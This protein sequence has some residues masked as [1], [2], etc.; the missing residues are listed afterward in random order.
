MLFLNTILAWAGFVCVCIPVLIGP[1]F[2]G[3]WE[4]WWFWPFTVFIF[5][6]SLFLA[7]RLC[8]PTNIEDNDS[9]QSALNMKEGANFRFK[10]LSVLSFL[11]FLVYAFIRFMQAEVFMDAERSLLLF[12]TPFLLGIQI[13]FGFNRKMR[14]VLF[15]FILADLFLLGLYGVINH[16]VW[17]STH[18]LWAEGYEQYVNDGRATGS[19]FCPDH[20]SGIM[21]LGFCLCLGL[22]LDRGTEWKRKLFAALLGVIALIGVVLSK[23]RGGGLTVIVIAFAALI[24][25]FSQWRTSVRW[26]WRMLLGACFIMILVIF[27]SIETPYMKRFKSYFRWRETEN[28]SFT[29]MKVIIQKRLLATSRGKM[30]SGAIRAWK[31]SPIIGIGPGMHQHLWPH[32]AASPDGDLELGVWPTHPNYEF[33]SYEVHSDWVQLLEE[34]GIVGLILFM[35]PALMVFGVLLAGHNREVRERK[36]NDYNYGR[37]AGAHAVVL[38]G[39]FAFVCMGFHSLG[40][41]NLQMPATVWLLA[42]ILSVAI[43]CIVT[44]A[45]KG[46]AAGE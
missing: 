19:Y 43:A 29:E 11:L 3:A 42:A 7:I 4:M 32:Y 16:C 30:I 36:Q 6:G 27:C 28:R 10:M 37:S 2:F 31:D 12:L 24:Y 46:Q 40:D 34:Y 45:S 25:G 21:E 9:G 8:L 39:I 15:V 44:T 38:S 13:V 18:V 23:S 35:I 1:W 17:R 5:L 26:Y 14:K 22:L 20:F 41:F 33:H